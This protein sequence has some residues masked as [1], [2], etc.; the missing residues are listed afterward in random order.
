MSKIKVIG[1]GSSGNCYLLEASTETMIIEAG[2]PFKKAAK[3]INKK[4]AGCIVSHRHG[5]HAG[6]L[7]DFADFARMHVNADTLAAYPSIAHTHYRDGERFN[8]G[9]FSVLPF[10]LW[11]DIECYGFSITRK[12]FGNLVF[13]TDTAR[14]DYMFDGI[15]NVMIECNFTHD[16]LIQNVMAGKLP[17]YVAERI[18]HSH[19]SLDKVIEFVRRHEKTLRRVILIHASDGNMDEAEAMAA[20]QAETSAVVTFADAGKEIELSDFF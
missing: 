13:I 18:S 3:Y 16:R 11:H 5:D 10:Q 17:A 4:I 15:T 1:S 9:S 19:L 8:V 14:V 20:I 6:Y 2:V 12:E 7:T